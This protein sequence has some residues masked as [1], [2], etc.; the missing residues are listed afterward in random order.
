M[1]RKSKN[2][3]ALLKIL[4]ELF[5]TT[6]IHEE[7]PI[8]IGNK[9]LYIDVHVPFFNIAFEIN[10]SQHYKFSK[11]MHGTRE[12]FMLQRL[13]DELKLEYCEKKGIRLVALKDTDEI[14]KEWVLKCMR[15]DDDD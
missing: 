2:H 11:F 3:D 1:Q 9:T 13:N 6:T 7:V 5:P 10:G 8:K 12:K 4:R 15:G 14:T